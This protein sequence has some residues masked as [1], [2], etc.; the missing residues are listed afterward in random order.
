MPSSWWLWW[1]VFMFVFLV[2]P[3]S[4]G[5]SYRGWGPPS[6][7]Y[8]QRRRA[9]NAVD[10]NQSATFDHQAWNWRGDAVWVMLFIATFWV[11]I[12]LWWR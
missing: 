3:L 11:C 5:W 6:P 2:S 8:I 1:T 4:Y 7:R 10:S 12:G 9:R